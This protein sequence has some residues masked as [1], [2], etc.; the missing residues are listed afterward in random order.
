MTKAQ[1]D[2][3][4]AVFVAFQVREGV[5]GGDV[6]HQGDGDCSVLGLLIEQVVYEPAGGLALTG[7]L[8]AFT[9]TPVAM[10]LG[11]PARITLTSY[12]R[13]AEAADV[14]TSAGLSGS[15]LLPGATSVA[16]GLPEDLVGAP[17]T[18]MQVLLENGDNIGDAVRGLVDTTA[19]PWTP[20]WVAS[21][22]L[23]A[24]SGDLVTAGIAIAAVI[25]R[26]ARMMSG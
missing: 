20:A 21:T 4:I 12:V 15:K 5:H 26:L 8:L 19:V 25:A 18:V 1:A 17:R 7:P 16:Q 11:R 13:M 9:F 2:D 14:T 3:V 10:M 23:V 22:P 24:G 6:Q